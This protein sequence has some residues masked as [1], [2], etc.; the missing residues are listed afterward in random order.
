M[1]VLRDLFVVGGCSIVFGIGVGML[2]ERWHWYR[3]KK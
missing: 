3:E 2:L 1:F